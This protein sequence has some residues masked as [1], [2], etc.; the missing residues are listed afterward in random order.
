MINVLND[1]GKTKRYK[2]YYFTIISHNTLVLH[3]KNGECKGQT[4]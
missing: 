2:C 4:S 1:Y 3:R